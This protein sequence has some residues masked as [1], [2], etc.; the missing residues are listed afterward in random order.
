MESLGNFSNYERPQAPDSDDVGPGWSPGFVVCNSSPGET[1]DHQL[2]LGTLVKT[3][4][5]MLI[6]VVRAGV[7]NEEWCICKIKL[8][9]QIT[10]TQEKL[11]EESF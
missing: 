1:Y 11:R 6:D 8:V 3:T 9:S 10:S 2:K 5:K 4:P 7:E